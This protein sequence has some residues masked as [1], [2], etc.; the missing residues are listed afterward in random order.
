MALESENTALREVLSKLKQAFITARTRMTRM[1]TACKAI[2]VWDQIE[3]LVESPVDLD[4]AVERQRPLSLAGSDRPGSP[5][6]SERPESPRQGS[7]HSSRPATEASARAVSIVVPPT[8]PKITVPALPESRRGKKVPVRP[9]PP[10]QTIHGGSSN[11]FAYGSPRLNRLL[12]ASDGGRRGAGTH[13]LKIDRAVHGDPGAGGRFA[14]GSSAFNATIVDENQSYAAVLRRQSYHADSRARREMHGNAKKE[15]VDPIFT[16]PQQRRAASKKR[17][18]KSK[19]EWVV[20]GT[21]S[22]DA[23]LFATLGRAPQGR[24]LTTDNYRRTG[25]DLRTWANFRQQGRAADAVSS[26]SATQQLA[27]AMN[28]AATAPAAPAAAAPAE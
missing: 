18:S 7:R 25:T 6:G 27:A 8:V 1:E 26:T 12:E 11:R 14:H 24:F 5:R 13:G 20:S 17:W 4:A 3:A 28:S 15:Q 19:N 16:R 23:S 22:E 21:D 9:R 2:G 10:D